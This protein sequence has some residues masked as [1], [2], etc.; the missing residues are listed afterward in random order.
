MNKKWYKK[1][2]AI[3]L[4]SVLFLTSGT[5]SLA[6]WKD[7][8]SHNTDPTVLSP[9]QLL[10]DKSN[11]SVW[12]LS[13]TET[14][15]DE[16]EEKKE[17]SALETAK[18]KAETLMT[19]Y[20]V[21]SVQ[22][23]LI[24]NGNITISGQSGFDDKVSKKAPT[25][26]TMYGIGSIS[27]MFT[28]V[29]VMQLVDQGKINLDA[30]VTTY[31]PEFKMEDSRYKNI[32]VRMLLNHSSGLLGSTL[33]NAMLLGDTNHD[34]Y[35]NFL[36][37][38]STQRLKADPGAFSVYCN[39]G[40]TL[41][42]LVVER[43]SGISFTEYIATY[44]SEPIGLK[45][46]KT[47]LDTFNKKQLA[48]IY[49]VL[50]S[51]KL[52]YEVFNMIGAGG[53]YSTAEDL[54]HFAEAFMSQSNDLLS[55]SSKVA[56][57]NNEYSNGK[58]VSPS[59]MSGYGLGWDTVNTYPFQE[60]N[61]KAVSK[62][63]DIMYYHGNII[64]LPYYNMAVAVLSSGGSGSYNQIMG[65]EILLAALK[66][67]GL[68]SEIKEPKVL[69]KPKETDMPEEYEDL[70]GIYA[71]FMTY[72]HVNVEDGTLTLTLPAYNNIQQKFIYTKDDCFVSS[73]GSVAIE[74]SKE[75][76]GNTYLLTKSYAMLQGIG[77]TYFYGYEAQKLFP[78]TLSSSVLK[79]W[80]ARD[81][82]IY[83]LVSER[84][85]SYLYNSG[86]VVAGVQINTPLKGYVGTSEIMDE[87]NLQV[88]LTIPMQYGRDLQ[89][90]TFFTEDGTEYIKIGEHVYVSAD[91]IKKI[92]AKDKFDV[93]IDSTGYAKYLDVS[94]TTANKTV[95]ITAPKNATFVVISGN[96]AV[97]SNYYIDEKDTVKLPKDGTLIFVG[98][99]NAVFTVEYI[100]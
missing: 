67:K 97:T 55:Y 48:G 32:T 83:A 6:S 33:E 98:D 39:D 10:F 59:K 36:K 38:L 34:A 3:V 65:Q 93:K 16:S 11:Q 40:F 2:L 92:S 1:G 15:I 100:K 26:Q 81:K 62:S 21:T 23:A 70:S 76:S 72:Y 4:A 27:K 50:S 91:S 87:N 88:N 46:T 60:Y 30:P 17:L 77:D 85:S 82:K 37:A 68:I 51:A 69:D 75:N 44:I 89:D 19:A 13:T 29:A 78:K 73:D 64:V 84:Y 52:P 63:G 57:E 24:D 66:E 22:Y 79:A 54:C 5:S 45:N 95:K 43:V 25:N 9:L 80:K 94:N 61:I 12:K 86:N 58:W 14:P 99:P 7:A 74:L 8:N 20:G 49:P 90:S 96:G 35:E 53:I 18:E 56:T 41:A 47:P 71:N 42:E 28:T 31:I